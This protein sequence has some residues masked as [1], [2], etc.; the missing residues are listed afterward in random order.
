MRHLG[1]CFFPTF[2]TRISESANQWST[3]VRASPISLS[4]PTERVMDP[5]TGP[6]WNSRVHGV[7]S[8]GKKMSALDWTL[9]KGEQ[10][11][12]VPGQLCMGVHVCH[13]ASARGVSA[14]GPWRE[15]VLRLM[16]SWV[17]HVALLPPPA[18]S[19]PHAA[20]MRKGVQG[21]TEGEARKR[22]LPGWEMG[23]LVLHCGY[24]LVTLMCKVISGTLS[25]TRDSMLIFFSFC[26]FL[27]MLSVFFF[28]PL[29][30]VGLHTSKKVW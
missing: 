17:E 26:F 2:G 28:F 3:W 5:R 24:S 12:T 23:F 6:W 14:E 27:F 19:A 1:L 10:G 4:F 15:I 29:G 22:H 21:S 18:P 16:E 7:F 11:R 9:G 13:W 30:G 8:I 20:G 25:L